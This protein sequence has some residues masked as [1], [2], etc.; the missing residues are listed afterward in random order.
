M[1]RREIA[2]ARDTL[3][4]EM[5]ERGEAI[6][7]LIVLSQARPSTKAA[8]KIAALAKDLAALSGAAL[9]LGGFDGR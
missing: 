2:Q 8:R 9:V 1:K 3:W 5:V 6:N 4:R 7:D